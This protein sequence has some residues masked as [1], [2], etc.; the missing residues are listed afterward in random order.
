MTITFLPARAS[1]VARFVDVRV[2]PVPP[3][4][5]S[6]QI[7]RLSLRSDCWALLTR[8]AC[9]RDAHR[10]SQLLLRLR[11]DRH[12]GGPRLERAA[13]EPVR[14]RRGEHDDRHVGGGAMRAVD[15]VQRPVVL[16]AL[17]GD[18]EQIGLSP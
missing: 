14:R 8:M 13:E 9:D 12:V 3:F 18:D 17:A 1:A 16:A 11:E 4:G 6:T 15:D 5:P 7:S 2:L 10:E